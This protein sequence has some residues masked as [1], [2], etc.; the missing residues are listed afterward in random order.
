MTTCVHE[1]VGVCRASGSVAL[2]GASGMPRTRRAKIVRS[3]SN[4]D[5]EHIEISIHAIEQ[6][7]I[8]TMNSTMN[9]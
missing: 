2:R 3:F 8:V 5:H 7:N 9:S 1:C 4:S 6:S